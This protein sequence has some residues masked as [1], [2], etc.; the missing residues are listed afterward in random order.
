MGYVAPKLMV[1]AAGSATDAVRWNVVRTVFCTACLDIRKS[2]NVRCTPSSDPVRARCTG[3]AHTRGQMQGAVSVSPFLEWESASHDRHC[4]SSAM[5]CEPTFVLRT[6]GAMQMV[7]YV[8]EAG[9]RRDEAGRI[10]SENKHDHE[11]SATHIRSDVLLAVHTCSGRLREE[12]TFDAEDSVP[13][14]LWVAN[15]IEASSLEVQS[16]YLVTSMN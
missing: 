7:E 5:G 16:E 13:V 12:R 15:A 1:A 2:R 9:L 4:H 11:Q 8:A 14:A 10:W 3:A 6:A